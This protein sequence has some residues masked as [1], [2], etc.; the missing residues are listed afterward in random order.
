MIYF[1]SKLNFLL[2]STPKFRIII[3]VAENRNR[4][5]QNLF[6]NFKFI[7][8]SHITLVAFL[9]KQT[10]VAFLPKRFCEFRFLFS[11][12]HIDFEIK[13]N[14]FLFFERKTWKLFSLMINILIS[15]TIFTD[16]L[17]DLIIYLPN[18]NSIQFNS[19]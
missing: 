3:C 16:L 13:R 17:L 14:I 5:L 15:L 10:T 8:N 7:W 1:R 2:K 11:A 19:K 4:I 9:S 18:F 6:S 12:T